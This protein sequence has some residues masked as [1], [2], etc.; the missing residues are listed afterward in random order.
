LK[1]A[2]NSLKVKYEV[3]A[4][5]G[6][7]YGPKIDIDAR[8]AMGRWWQL[9]TVQLDFFMP[10]RFDLTY[11]DEKG[12]KQRPIMIH[13]AMY[14]AFERFMG[15][16]IE[17]YGGAFPSWLAPVQVKVLNFTDRNLRYA[18]KVEKALRDA[19]IRVESDY[20]SL[21]VGKKVRNAEM[22]KVPYIL[23]VGDKEQKAG[24]VAVRTRGSRKLA[25][26]VKVDTFIKR[27]RKEIDSKKIAP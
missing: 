2:L 10:D 20:D 25:F 8:D 24:T 26:G 11:V 7:F 13:V 17:H 21:T 3:K 12:K 5:E 6:A 15:V 23:V 27:I 16:L 1:S 4:G 19:D 14:G 18:Q 9:S 22:E